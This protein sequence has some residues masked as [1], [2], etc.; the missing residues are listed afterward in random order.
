M[1][2]LICVTAVFVA[3]AAMAQAPTD[4]PERSGPNN[5]PNQRICRNEP[6]LGS[7]VN[8]MRICKTRAEWADSRSQDRRAIEKAQTNR[9]SSGR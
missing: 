1:F 7:R 6:V 8:R 3:T 2:K 4:V 5:D 9:P